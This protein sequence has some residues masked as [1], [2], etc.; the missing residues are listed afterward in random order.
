MRKTLPVL[1]A[2]VR[3]ENERKSDSDRKISVLKGLSIKKFKS[4]RVN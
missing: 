3:D 2:A 1:L 4:V